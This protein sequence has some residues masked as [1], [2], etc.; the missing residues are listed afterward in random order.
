MTI[1]P[2]GD[3]S[4]GLMAVAMEDVDSLQITINYDTSTMADVS[5]S[6][7]GILAMAKYTE[8]ITDGTVQVSATESAAV[9]GSGYILLLDYTRVSEHKPGRIVSASVFA[10]DKNGRQESVPVVINDPEPPSPSP[11]AAPL[12]AI[13]SAVGETPRER[14]GTAVSPPAAVSD[15]PARAY[16]DT[17][18]PVNP[19]Q[20]TGVPHAGLTQCIAYTSVLGR[21]R[22]YTGEKSE[23]TILSFLTDD[24][25]RPF[26]QE[27]FVALSDG[28][29]SVR[30]TMDLDIKGAKGPVFVLHGA[31]FLTLKSRRGAWTLEVV[32]V[33]GVL[34]ASVTAMYDDRV[35][36]FPLTLAPPLPAY[37]KNR[38]DSA[39]A[40]VDTYVTLVNRLANGG[41]KNDDHRNR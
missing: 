12:P 18:P 32:P 24:Q 10:V 3:T 19:G 34:E 15:R 6:P 28:E 26:R 2:T 5:A 23:K 11:P 4:F 14:V 1:T 9:D 36:E 21:I 22:E 39:L 8:K 41:G 25:D 7:T 33:R 30:I 20:G 37:L 29:T 16:G 40:Y 27:P 31:Q 35:V 17:Q 13:S 38:P